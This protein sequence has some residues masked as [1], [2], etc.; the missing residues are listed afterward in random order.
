M[1]SLRD[2]PLLFDNRIILKVLVVIN[3]ASQIPL[4]PASPIVLASQDRMRE[5]FLP[6]TLRENKNKRA[7]RL[8]AIMLLPEF[9]TLRHN[10]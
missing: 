2:D 3:T 9:P 4:D 6:G 5:Q 1:N 7:G 8:K 10:G